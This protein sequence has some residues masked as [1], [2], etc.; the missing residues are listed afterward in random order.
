V[1]IANHSLCWQ[2]LIKMVDETT[3]RKNIEKIIIND[4]VDIDSL[5]VEVFQGGVRPD[6]EFFGGVCGEFT[7]KISYK[8]IAIRE[9]GLYETGYQDN[10]VRDVKERVENELDKLK[11]DYCEQFEKQGFIEINLQKL[12]A[13]FVRGY[14]HTSLLFMSKEA[15]V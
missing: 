5:N 1:N 7:I 8:E 6:P 14:E 12:M 15:C 13:R 11:G 3:E 4:A 2:G 10:V 9:K